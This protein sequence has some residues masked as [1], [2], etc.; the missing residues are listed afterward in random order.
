M[1]LDV[2]RIKRFKNFVLDSTLHQISFYEILFIEKGKG[3]FALDENKIKI[4]TCAIIFT[5]PGQVR[6][7]DIKQP[8]SGYTL[9][10]EKIS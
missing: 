1:L 8:V 10:F 7:W 5:S 4:E 6:Q 3:I 9:F 2:A